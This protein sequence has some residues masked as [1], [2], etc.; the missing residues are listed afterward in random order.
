MNAHANVAWFAL[1][2]PRSMAARPTLFREA[3]RPRS[4][5]DYLA[6]AL[7]ALVAVT[8]PAFLGWICAG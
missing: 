4:A 7:L 2:A 5:V 8:P 6:T 3:L 1:H